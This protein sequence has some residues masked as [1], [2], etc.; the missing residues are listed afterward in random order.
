MV[1]KKSTIKTPKK[2]KL[3][4]SK[5][6]HKKSPS[7]RKVHQNHPTFFN[8]IDLFLLFLYILGN[9]VYLVIK[10]LGKLCTHIGSIIIGTTIY[11]YKRVIIIPTHVTRIKLPKP[12]FDW[13]KNNLAKNFPN[14]TKIKINHYYFLLVAFIL[15]SI[16]FYKNVIKDLPD[17]ATLAVRKQLLTTQIYDRKGRLLYKLYK[18]ENRTLVPLGFVPQHLINAVISIEDKNFYK[19]HGFSP[20]GAIRAFYMNIKKPEE[21]QGGST[22]TQQLIKNTLLTKEKSI[23]RKTK[24]VILSIQTELLYSKD[25]ILEMYLN[26]VGFGGPIYG[27]QEAA[28]YYFDKN[29]SDLNLAESSFL[30]GLPQAPTRLSPFGINKDLGKSRQKKVLDSMVQNGFISNDEAQLAYNERLVFSN[31]KTK[32]LAPHFIQYLSELLTKEYGEDL[33]SK[34]Y[35]ITSSLDLDLQSFAQNAINEELKRIN[36]LNVTNGATLITNPSTGEILAMIGSKNYFDE[37]VDGQVNMTTSLRQ[38]GST[39]KPINYALAFEN[40]LSPS[41]LIDDA[42]LSINQYGETYTPT[43]YDGRFHGKISLREALANSYNI[44]AV[45]ILLQNGT[46][47]MATMAQRLGITSWGDSKRYGLSMTLGS[48]EVKMTDMAEVYGTIANQG[49]RVPLKSILEIKDSSGKKISNEHCDK[50]YYSKTFSCT[51]EFVLK[52]STAYLITDILKDPIARSQAFGFN[53]ILNIKGQEIAVKTGTSNN[54]KDNWTIGYTTDYLVATW[55][56]NNNGDSMSNVASGITGAS[57]IWHNIFQSITKDKVHIFQR[58]ES[59]VTLPIC[60]TTNTL[61]CKECPNIK[62]ESYPK[63]QE[64]KQKCYPKDFEISSE[65]QSNPIVQNLSTNTSLPAFH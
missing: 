19:H 49:I 56:G 60:R 46:T 18:D 64:P 33:Y 31:P 8:P 22:I 25:S 15:L 11:L 16:A 9:P 48:L 39:V 20:T 38:P 2:S 10:I 51:P 32:I 35:Q 34:G 62:I 44:P 26:E 17:P 4:N 42:P 37:S 53:S 28:Q 29:V 13:I 3:Q 54:L 30:A 58:P 23:I 59:I 52:P 63:G 14:H 36:K 45:K 6:Y 24:E 61:A 7:I 41:T 27:V 65:N 1:E 55:V 57:P 40:G 47:N 50:Y 12:K 21:L 5:T 43:N